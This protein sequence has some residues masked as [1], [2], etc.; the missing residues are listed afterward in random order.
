MHGHPHVQE[1]LYILDILE[2]QYTG[3]VRSTA[4]AEPSREEMTAAWRRLGVEAL[5]AS[6]DDGVGRAAR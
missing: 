6:G 2:E 4:A 5:F 3:G 1:T